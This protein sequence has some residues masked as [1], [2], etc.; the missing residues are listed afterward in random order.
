MEDLVKFVRPLG[1]W[2]SLPPS[3]REEFNEEAF[4][5]H[6]SDSYSGLLQYAKWSV[7]LG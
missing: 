6:S 7:D 3:K 5:R 2:A 1:G 4:R